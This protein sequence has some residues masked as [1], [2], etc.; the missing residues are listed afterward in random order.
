M[1]DTTMNIRNVLRL[2]ARQRSA[3][4]K[5]LDSRVVDQVLDADE[6][7]TIRDRLALIAERDDL[8]RKAAA[9]APAAEAKA[10]AAVAR[11]EKAE[12]D[13]REAAEAERI[14]K[15]LCQSAKRHKY[16]DGIERKLLASA[17]PRVR[18]F[19][20]YLTY[21]D[22]RVH[23]AFRAWPYSP[24]FG[25][26]VLVSNVEEVKAARAVLREF[27]AK[28]HAIERQA[29]SYADVTQEF[30]GMCEHLAP[31]LAK[32]LF[33]PPQLANDG[34]VG[35]PILFNDRSRWLVDQVQERPRGEEAAHALA[36]ED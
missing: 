16:I 6:Q 20:W 23:A 1:K 12:A 21:L 33:N 17:D 8:Q 19:R 22:D 18:E 27:I 36:T 24:G 3:L 30:V 2:T 13:L 14:A 28:T 5:L 29:L 35:E 31:I 34:E 15:A 32:L 10:A 7:D 4:D 11:R 25:R 26:A 9:E